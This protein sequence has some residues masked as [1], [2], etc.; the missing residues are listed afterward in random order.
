MGREL[1][2]DDD[3]NIE[4]GETENL[5]LE[6]E[7]DDDEDEQG[8]KEEDEEND[9]R[10]NAED[11]NIESKQANPTTSSTIYP[12]AMSMASA[13]VISHDLAT[14]FAVP[15]ITVKKRLPGAASHARSLTEGQFLKFLSQAE[16]EKRRKEEEKIRA[17]KEREEKKKA[18]EEERKRKEDARKKKEE[19]KKEKA[20]G[21]TT[22]WCDVC[23][24]LIE[25]LEVSVCSNCGYC[26]HQQCMTTLRE[27]ISQDIVCAN[28]LKSA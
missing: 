8:E 7:E 28:C 27:V 6:D 19:A 17:R 3:D 26:F 20:Q 14:L 2:P 13:G 4:C 18:K 21:S 22:A 1:Q 25:K 15:S 16:E 12:L 11:G 23:G 24:E 10:V 9:E 5:Q